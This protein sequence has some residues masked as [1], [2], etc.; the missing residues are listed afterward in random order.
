MATTYTAQT[1]CDKSKREASSQQGTLGCRCPHEALDG[2]C[3]HPRSQCKVGNMVSKM[4]A[5]PEISLPSCRPRPGDKCFLTDKTPEGQEKMLFNFFHSVLKII[6]F[7]TTNM[8]FV[9]MKFSESIAFKTCCRTS[10]SSTTP[11][12][13]SLIFLANAEA[14]LSLPFVCR[15]PQTCLRFARNN[16]HNSN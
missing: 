15:H 11:T 7:G 6:L 5:H 3:T 2:G 10:A 13:G 9:E 4:A 12:Y 1:P 14:S 8:Q 16:F